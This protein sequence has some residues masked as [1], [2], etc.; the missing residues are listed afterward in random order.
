M[1]LHSL[2]S[3]T[4][5]ITGGGS[6]IGKAISTLFAAQGAQVEIL[7]VD[8]AGGKATVEGIRAAGG[9]A[10]WIR[11]DVSDKSSVDAAFAQIEQ[12][13]GS[14]DILVN[15]A[16]VAHVGNALNTEESDF[17][18]L[19]RINVRS[20]YLCSQA[21][22]RRMTVAK[23]GVILNV[24]STASLVAIADRFAYSMS[25]GAV[26]TMTLS[27]AKDFLPYNIRCN[28]VCPA[29]IHTPFVDGFI[30]KNYAGREE[31]MFEKLSKDQPIGRMGRP[32]E[33][34]QA[35]LF[36]CSDEASF[37]TGCA[38]PVDGGFLNLR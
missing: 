21:A 26:L 6:G 17:D 31:E 20:I 10:E 19:Y 16:G 32:E 34:A 15:N 7:D 11:C 38:Y 3:K 18:R 22:L 25:K 24:A 29:R 9:K 2:D 23:R 14:I 37:M 4:A 8:E 28:A 36:L 5:L 13:H 27:I 30:K 33:V 12:Q 35:A 1:S